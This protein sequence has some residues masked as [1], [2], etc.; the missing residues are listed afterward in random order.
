MDNHFALELS[1]P[2]VTIR[3]PG[4]SVLS[5]VRLKDDWPGVC[6]LSP[7]RRFDEGVPRHEEA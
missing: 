7:A 5:Y 4:V 2:G 6:V 1:I 3:D